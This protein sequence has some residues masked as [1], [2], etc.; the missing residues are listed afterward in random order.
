MEECQHIDHKSEHFAIRIALNAWPQQESNGIT[1][2]IVS[3][4]NA[5]IKRVLPPEKWTLISHLA[6]LGGMGI[7]D[8]FT[9]TLFLLLLIEPIISEHSNAGADNTANKISNRGR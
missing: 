5:D 4:L 8:A 9:P 1:T 6:E 2:I 3:D 7:V